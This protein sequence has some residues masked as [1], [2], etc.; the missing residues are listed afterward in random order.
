MIEQQYI[1][2]F[3]EYRSEIDANS[4]AGLNRHR[5]AAFEAFDKSGFPTSKL[6]DYKHTDVSR[7][8][9]G[10]SGLNLRN[11]HKSLFK[12]P[13]LRQKLKKSRNFHQS[14]GPKASMSEI[15]Q[16]QARVA[17]APASH[18]ENC[19]NTSF[20]CGDKEKSVNCRSLR[21][22]RQMCQPRLYYQSSNK[23]YYMQ[24]VVN[25]PD[26]SSGYEN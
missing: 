2:L 10:D 22:T 8:F 17:F 14:L 19:C 21:V 26:I 3:N 16:G 11:I 12:T 13:S 5:D 6:E 9:D 24:Y 15:C 18:G 23:Y 25:R 20:C 7:A 1:D 4:V